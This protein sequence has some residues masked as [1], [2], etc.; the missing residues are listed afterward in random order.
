MATIHDTLRTTK[1]RADRLKAVGTHVINVLDALRDLAPACVPVCEQLLT[2][3]NVAAT[4]YTTA[5]RELTAALPT[6]AP[7]PVKPTLDA[8]LDAALVKHE[9]AMEREMD[10]V[11]GLLKE[12]TPQQLRKLATDNG[13]PTTGSG[14]E[15]AT[16]LVAHW[17]AKADA[18]KVTP[19]APVAVAAQTVAPTVA[20][21][22]PVTKTGKPDKR[23]KA[24][25]QPVQQH[26][27]KPRA[28][29]VAPARKTTPVVENG[30]AAVPQ[31]VA[32]TVDV[33]GH[34]GNMSRATM[35]GIISQLSDEQLRSMVGLLTE[36]ELVGAIG[37]YAK[38]V[39]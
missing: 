13:I 9:A 30:I 25:R 18:A 22:V 32:V 1:T 31:K 12:T 26:I 35:L 28:A 14:L 6:N 39:R 33:V 23:F 27:D 34:I 24:N 4:D 16:A 8:R 20:P 29:D 15:I 37:D 17:V 10:P 36:K 11:L 2:A 38:T 7:A 5:I 19:P 21:T 3:V